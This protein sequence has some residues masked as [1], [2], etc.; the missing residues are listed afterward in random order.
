[1]Y[2]LQGALKGAALPKL[3]RIVA[4]NKAGTAHEIYVWQKDDEDGK[5]KYMPLNSLDESAWE[6]FLPDPSVEADFRSR[7]PSPKELGEVH[8]L[9]VVEGRGKRTGGF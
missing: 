4:Y 7:Y 1:M 2:K 6:Q 3:N 9:R 8:F 5:M